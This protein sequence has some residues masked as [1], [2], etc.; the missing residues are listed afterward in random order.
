MIKKFIEWIGIKGKLHNSDHVP[1]QFKEGE[2][3]WCHMGEN[4][5]I[6]VN[7]KS[8]LFTR[9][10]LIFK[11]Y[12]RYSFLGLPL[13]TKVKTGTWYVSISLK[14][15]DQ[16]V[17]LVQGRTYDYRRLKEK[18]GELDKSHIQSVQ[19]GY[20]DLHITNIKK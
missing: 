5:G 8:Q 18:V 16:V 4:V 7:G 14:G 3:W 13:T 15:Q 6:E 12:D 11:K 20:S 17:V 1:P 2:V 10:V 9:P 19:K